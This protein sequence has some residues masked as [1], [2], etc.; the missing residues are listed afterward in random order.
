[1]QLH[2]FHKRQ[3]IMFELHVHY[4]DNIF[5]EKIGPRLQR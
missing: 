2:I 5:I 3:T 1:M 4:V